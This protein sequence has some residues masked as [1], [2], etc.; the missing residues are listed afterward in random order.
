MRQRGSQKVGRT[1]ERASTRTNVSVYMDICEG[2]SVQLHF[3]YVTNYK[4]KQFLCICKAV[5]G[6]Y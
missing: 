5:Q 4:I 1:K 6:S 2:T 3:K